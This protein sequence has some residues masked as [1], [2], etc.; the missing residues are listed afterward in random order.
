MV[1]RKILY[2]FTLLLILLIILIF[3]TK[4]FNSPNSRF[5]E[6]SFNKL[7]HTVKFYDEK[8]FL[9][10]V[11][12]QNSPLYKT[13]S[14]LTKPD[15]SIRGGI[16]PHHL[17]AS[18]IIADFFHRLSI[19][20][21]STII[22]LGPNHYE[23]GSFEVLT[24]IYNW[25]TSF[26]IVEPDEN[27]AKILIDKNLVTVDEEILPNDHS[28]SALMPF[29]KYY[30]PNVKVVPILLSKRF[31]KEKSDVFADNLRKLMKENIVVV[32][33]VDFSHYLTS[34]QAKEKDEISLEIMKNFDY[35]RLYSL[36]NDYL[37]S[38]PSIGILLMLMQ[39]LNTT[40]MEIL[41][42]T[43]SGELQNNNQVETTSYFSILLH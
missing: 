5:N 38:P 6:S 39:K 16:V 26:G 3:I 14:N 23:K 2:L 22:L 9:D 34:S 20:N 24:S 4:K 15:Y 7:T 21:P 31:S 41:Y 32:A 36:S 12:E 27:L 37:D 35:R 11:Y 19:Q 8:T 13:K 29:I 25:D 43:N 18:F 40:D 30:M 10:G 1:N 28:L 42:H 17:F 33:S